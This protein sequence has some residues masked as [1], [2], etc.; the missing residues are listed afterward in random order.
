MENVRKNLMLHETYYCPFWHMEQKCGH[1]V[2]EMQVNYK[3]RDEVSTE[4]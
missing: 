3:H 4:Y 1:G 2:R